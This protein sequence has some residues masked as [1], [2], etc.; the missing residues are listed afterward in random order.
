M[1]AEGGFDTAIVRTFK[2]IKVADGEL[3]IRAQG[4]GRK[5]MAIEVEPGQ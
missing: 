2:G 1:L 4:T 3:D 5:V